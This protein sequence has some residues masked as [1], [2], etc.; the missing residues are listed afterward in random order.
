V[1][2]WAPWRSAGTYLV[3]SPDSATAAPTGATAAQAAAARG[4]LPARLAIPAIGVTAP[5]EARGTVRSKN[6]F[7]GQ[8]VDGYGVPSSMSATSWWS[9]GPQ[10]GSGRMAVIL[11]HEQPGG[12]YAVFNDLD[13]LRPGDPVDIYDS[14][15]AVVHL[16]VLAAPLTGLAK[17]TSA[18]GDA[19][20]HHPA[21][22]DVALV[23]CGGQFDQGAGQ[24]KDNT[25]VFATL[26]GR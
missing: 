8:V 11:G 2:F 16:Q 1:L 5:V 26:G 17:S 20:N 14:G 25:V 24:S 23:T 13:R 18:L 22:A 15:G 6:P 19:L 3:G 9:D 10:P 12:G 21:G 7:T 4:I